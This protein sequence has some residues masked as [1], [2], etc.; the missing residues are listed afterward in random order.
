L[1]RGFNSPSERNAGRLD[2]NVVALINALTG[3]N[4]KINYIERESKYVKLTEFEE[5]EAENPNK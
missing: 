1:E 5:T 3:T 2:P 4:L